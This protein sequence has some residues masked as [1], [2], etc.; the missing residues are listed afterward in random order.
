MTEDNMLIEDKVQAFSQDY[1]EG[2]PDYQTVVKKAI[3]VAFGK[4][5]KLNLRKKN[6]FP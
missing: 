1:F 4:S 5:K 2:H 3:E 6:S